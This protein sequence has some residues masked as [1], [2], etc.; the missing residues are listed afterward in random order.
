M[1]LDE[2]SWRQKSRIQWLK[3]GDKNTKFFHRTANANRHHNCIESITYGE[4][5]WETQEEIHKGIVDFYQDLYSEKEHWRPVLGGV[6]F[7][8]LEAEEAAHLERPFSEEEVVLALNQISGEKALGPDGFT[9]AFF[10]HC[11]DVV[12]KEV[13]DSL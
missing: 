3:E 2:V 4:S 5:R 10:H 12:K 9:L 6:D 13:L 11:W 8:S 1:L 7:T